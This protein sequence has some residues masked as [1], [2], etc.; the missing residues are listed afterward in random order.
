MLT[1]LYWLV[2]ILIAIVVVGF[3]LVLRFILYGIGLLALIIIIGGIIA[4]GLK[5]VYQKD[6]P[7]D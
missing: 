2:G 4:T 5:E 1:T 3:L 6:K 7:P